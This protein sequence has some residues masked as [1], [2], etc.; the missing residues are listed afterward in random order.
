M[1]PALKFLIFLII[2]FELAF[3]KN[4]FFPL[5]VIAGS[6]LYLIL[7]KIGIKRLMFLIFIGAL[8]ALLSFITYKNLSTV[9]TGNLPLVMSIRIYAYIFIGAASVTGYSFTDLV[10]SF[11]QNL[12]LSPTFAYGILGGLNFIPKMNEQIRIIKINAKMRGSRMSPISPKIYLKAI[13]NALN[14]S[15]TL[16]AAMYSHG[17]KEGQNRTHFNYQS[18]KISELAIFFLI[19]LATIILMLIK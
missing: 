3:A 5:V 2:G 8:P 14:W 17:F 12:K 10:R 18:I 16:S 6:F 7:N 13:Y 19:I 15:N 1:K 9:D 11:E 4:F